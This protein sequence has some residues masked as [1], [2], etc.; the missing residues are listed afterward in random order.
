MT[1]FRERQDR[2]S[3][4]SS[5]RS[6][7]LAAVALLLCL[8]G[9]TQASASFFS[10]GYVTAISDYV[11]RGISQT[12]E[13]PALQLGLDFAWKQLSFSFW[14]TNVDFG[15]GSGADVETDLGV[16][17]TGQL[18]QQVSVTVAALR[19]LYSGDSSLNYSEF[20][21]SFG[22]EATSLGFY[23]SPDYSGTP[24]DATYIGLSHSVSLPNEVSLGLAVGRNGFDASTGSVDYWDYGVTLSRS[25]G[26]VDASLAY[27]NTDLPDD[28]LS[29]DRIVGGLTV[30]F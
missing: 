21:V 10:G 18:T 28:R 7:R 17:W 13:D 23:L 19:Y 20:S 1:T 3:T 15:P 4:S 6:V 22:T 16:S 29:N 26:K 14:S 24:G 12:E 27:L 5:R 25:F 30:N 9:G 8:L 2:S 11:F